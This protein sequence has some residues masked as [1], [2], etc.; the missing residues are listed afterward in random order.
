MGVT[1]VISAPQAVYQPSLVLMKVMKQEETV[2]SQHVQVSLDQRFVYQ[3]RVEVEIS[4][5]Q[6][7]LVELMELQ[8]GL[9]YL[10]GLHWSRWRDGE[11]EEAYVIL[12]VSMDVVSMVAEEEINITALIG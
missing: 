11:N 7:E 5:E 12:G 8:V 9:E 3:V 6:E 2:I 10:L 4:T 1:R